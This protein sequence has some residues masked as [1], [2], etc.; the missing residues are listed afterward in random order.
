M[1]LHDHRAKV[2]QLAN[3]LGW[4]EEHCRKQPEMTVHAA[5][6]RLAA[7]L[8]RNVVG[9]A[10]EGIPAPPLH[11]AVV[12]GAGAGKSTIV[13][14]LLGVNVADANPQAGYTRHPTAYYAE[15]LKFAW[16]STLG[17]MGPLRRLSET[18]PAN[19]D[20]DVYQVQRVPVGDGPISEMVVWDCPD[21]TTW[22]STAYVS[23]LIETAAL[24][25]VIVY[26]ASDERYNDEVPTQFLRLLVQAG[27]AIVVC[28]TK[29]NERNVP[30]LIE[31]FRSEIINRLPQGTPTPTIPVMAIPQLPQ[32]ARRDPKGLAAS[33]REALLKPILELAPDPE[34]TRART[35]KNAVHYLEHASAGLLELARRDLD[36][37]EKWRGLVVAGQHQFEERYRN[38]FL[39][40]ESFQRFDRT[41]EQVMEMLELP[42]PGRILSSILSIL[43]LPYKYGRDFLTKI[44][45]RPP[46]TSQSERGVSLA[47]LAAW[48][49]G[50]QAETLRRGNTHPI[51]K[52]LTHGFDAGLKAN[53]KDQFQSI[54]RKFELIE[55]DELE[56]ETRAIPERLAQHPPMLNLLRLTVIMLD[57][58]II[59]LIVWL[60]WPPGWYLLALIPL[61]MSITRQLVEVIVWQL[62]E[63]GRARLKRHREV[64]LHEHL[65][66]PMTRWLNDWPTTGG[67]NLERLQQVLRRI[68]TTIAELTAIV[69][70]RTPISEHEPKATP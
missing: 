11:I 39:L 45:T 61:A 47:A 55:R 69:S 58:T 26:V 49:D 7:A 9:P 23:R 67:S 70:Q 66:E 63:R 14:F 15:S 35:L 28:L 25:D 5:K 13:N 20:E 24:A 54:Y 48:L 27:K 30:S 42:G 44:L 2:R 56:Q 37:L 10:A 57:L 40:G 59:G 64:L 19:L 3:D 33:N 36:E 60:T 1:E 68:P 38:E 34:T 41:R 4:L 46:I 43:R 16:P 51:W 52:Q 17:F 31:H 22:A 50:L 65:S 32:A 6:L 29:A 12:G 62:I 21:M 53:A 18:K 8:S